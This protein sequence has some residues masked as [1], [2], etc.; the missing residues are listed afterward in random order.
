MDRP[1][2][3]KRNGTCPESISLFNNIGRQ[4]P[5]GRMKKLYKSRKNK[6]VDGV[7]GGIAEYLD[8][9][10]VLIRLI[11][12]LFF[13]TG[14]ATLIAYIVGMIIIPHQPPED[15]RE[16]E[17]AQA[18]NVTAS[19]SQ[20]ESGGRAGSLIFGILMILFG[21]HFL[22]SNIPFFYQYYW[23]LWDL[24]RDFFWPSALIVVGLL[25]IIR[26]VRK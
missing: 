16:S 3:Q 8:M 14:G 17:T 23:R 15:A 12:V 9:D 20:A 18:P 26:G 6:V 11:A 2:N 22:L 24:S 7:C 10:P 1:G 25:V 13:F 21:I 5:G 4:T 19:C